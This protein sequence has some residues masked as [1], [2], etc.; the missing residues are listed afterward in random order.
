MFIVYHG[1]VTPDNC[2][3]SEGGGPYKLEVC[4]TEEQVLMLRKQHEE[5][6]AGDESMRPVFRVFEGEEVHLEA[7]AVVTEW[8]FRKKG[9]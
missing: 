7:K 6:V 3:A 1:Y 9:R 2:D 4:K 8:A 5:D